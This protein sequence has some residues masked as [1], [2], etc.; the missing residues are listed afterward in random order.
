MHT[1]KQFMHTNK[2]I[3]C[4]LFVPILRLNEH[5]S[6]G[7]L[8]FGGWGWGSLKSSGFECYTKENLKWRKFNIKTNYIKR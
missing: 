8:A 7:K 5:D 3:A 1:G 2:P 4:V 6:T